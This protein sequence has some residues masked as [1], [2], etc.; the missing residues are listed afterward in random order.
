M[1]MFAWVF[2]FGFFG[3][4]NTGSGLWML[5]V[6]CIVYGIAFDFFNVSGG[7]YVDQQT[8]PKI[9]SS[10]QGLFMIMT[11]GIGATVGTLA[12]QSIVNHLVFTQTTPEAQ[13]AGWTTAWYIFAAYALVVA[14]LFL[15]I[16][17]DT[18]SPTAEEARTYIE[19]T[20]SAPEGDV[21][22]I[23]K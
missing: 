3:L 5:I 15:I 8:S 6:S 18:K 7:L 1:A 10:A 16:F 19:E 21:E 4:G 17:K 2:R 12:A 13:H 9:R 20:D 14:V 11:N 23:K 22:D